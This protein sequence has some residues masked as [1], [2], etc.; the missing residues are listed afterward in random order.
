MYLYNFP[1]ANFLFMANEFFNSI[2]RKQLDKNTNKYDDE[3]QA[4]EC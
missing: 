4:L 2:K 1:Q 3:E